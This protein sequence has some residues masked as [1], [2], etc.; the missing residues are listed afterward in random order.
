[1]NLDKRRTQVL[2]AALDRLI[3][4]QDDLPSACAA[5]VDVYVDRQLG[6]ERF[7][8]IKAEVR[9]GLGL[10]DTLAKKRHRRRFHEL[11][12]AAQDALLAAM[13][14]GTAPTAGFQAQ[15][16]FEILHTLAMEGYLSAPRHGGNR[17]G[18]AWKALGI[19][20]EHN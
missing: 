17:D 3:P 12:G 13:Q 6:S 1:M 18:I 10:L 11:D 2:R 8:G 19:S 14:T 15:R 7:A 9:R 20:W 16:F 4:A 5:R